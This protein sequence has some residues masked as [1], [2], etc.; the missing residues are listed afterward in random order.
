MR[1]TLTAAVVAAVI[2]QASAHTWVEEM[3]VIDSTS[4]NYTGDHGFTRGYVART[5]PGYDGDEAIKYLLPPL[6]TGR[7]RI[8]GTDLLCH[9]SQRTSN[10][11]NPEYPRLQASPGSYVAMKYLENG[12]VTLPE[13]QPG[14]PK[15]GGTVF[16]YATTKPSDTEKIVDV[17]KWNTA[18]TGGDSRGSQIA[19]Q[20]YDDGRCHQ[21]NT[22]PISVQRQQEFPDH[23]IGQPDSNVEQWCETD[24]HIPSTYKTGDTV[25]VYWVWQWPTAP[26]VGVYPNGKDEYYTSCAEIEIVDSVS[27]A[28]PVHTLAQQDA[29]SMAVSDFKSRAVLTSSALYTLADGSSAT[30]TAEPV[31][32]ATTASSVASSATTASPPAPSAASP[33]ASSTTLSPPSSESTVLPIIVLPPFP[34][35]NTSSPST[36]PTYNPSNPFP[37]HPSGGPPPSG[38]NPSPPFFSPGPQFPPLPSFV[39]VTVTNSVTG[40][41]NKAAGATGVDAGTTK[42]VTDFVTLYVTA[43]ASVVVVPA[44][45]SAAASV[46]ATLGIQGLP[47]VV[48]VPD[49]AGNAGLIGRSRVFRSGR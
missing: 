36:G 3:Q 18:G 48:A 14:K 37:S 28:P 7:T 15:M 2:G 49:Q 13:N 21:L 26:G 8:D 27:N 24:V 16:V 25:T 19:A 9:P 32:S 38:N 33:T 40:V 12:H 30:A 31:S 23:V 34:L 5:D 22:G 4:G 43:A 35:T 42:T 45:S 46:V 10:Y 1:F 29:Q 6:S 41:A 44:A 20:N 17:L 39:T 47:S 11:N